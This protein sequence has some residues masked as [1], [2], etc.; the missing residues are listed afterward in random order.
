MTDHP[1][2]EQVEPTGPFDREIESRAIAKSAIWLAVTT[3]AAFI[4]SWFLYLGLAHKEERQDPTPSPLAAANEPVVPPEPRLQGSP[5]KELAAFRAEENKELEGWS[6]VDRDAG[7]AHVPIEVAIDSV[8]KAGQLPD[9][10]T[11]PQGAGGQ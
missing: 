2:D 6:W 5:E 1:R 7:I 3:V 10:A 9:L 8:A 11:P 4:I